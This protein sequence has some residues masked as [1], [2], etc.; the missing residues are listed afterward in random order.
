LEAKEAPL[1][2]KDTVSGG[3]L[4]NFKVV[5]YICSFAAFA[6]SNPNKENYYD[7]RIFAKTED[8]FGTNAHIG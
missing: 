1:S 3:T 8:R 2:R 5:K 7:I 6:Q 4:P